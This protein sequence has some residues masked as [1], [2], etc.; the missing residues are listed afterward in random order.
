M[1]VS[2]IV[3]YE[4]LSFDVAQGQMNGALS[5]TPHLSTSGSVMVGKL[6]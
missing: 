4:A 1:C 2:N 3:I 5:E 6:D